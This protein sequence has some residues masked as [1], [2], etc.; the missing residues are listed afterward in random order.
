MFVR[1]P[2]LP[3]PI[4][5]DYNQLQ[6]YGITCGTINHIAMPATKIIIPR[7]TSLDKYVQLPKLPQQEEQLAKVF[8]PIIVAS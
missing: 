7:F 4:T 6:G 8:L 5:N 1:I 2:Y 3:E